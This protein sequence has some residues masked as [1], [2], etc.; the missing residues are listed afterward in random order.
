MTAFSFRSHTF[1]VLSSGDVWESMP[2]LPERIEER[3]HVPYSAINVVDDGGDGL[4]IWPL[5]IVVTSSEMANILADRGLTG[6]LVTP[7]ATY[8]N[9][10]LS[11]I[12][13]VRGTRA[14]D[15]YALET[16][17]IVGTA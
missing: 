14:R 11:Q 10:K 9:S 15:E 1:K 16:E 12:R 2:P 7:D 17:W 8:P 3:T 5:T 6:T 13:S 4:R